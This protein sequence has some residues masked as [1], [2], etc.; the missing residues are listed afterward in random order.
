M[1]KRHACAI[2]GLFAQFSD[3]LQIYKKRNYQTSK[4]FSFAKSHMLTK[5]TCDKSVRRSLRWNVFQNQRI[6]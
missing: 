2:A 1:A 3:Q 5:P 4:Q 6:F